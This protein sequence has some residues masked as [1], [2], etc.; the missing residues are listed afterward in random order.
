MTLFIVTVLFVDIADKEHWLVY[1]R[2]VLRDVFYFTSQKKRT[3]SSYIEP[4]DTEFESSCRKIRPHSSTVKALYPRDVLFFYQSTSG[5]YSTFYFLRALFPD[6]FSLVLMYLSWYSVNVFLLYCL[7]F[8]LLHL[9]YPTLQ[10]LSYSVT[11]ISRHEKSKIYVLLLS[12]IYIEH[13][14]DAFIFI[15]FAGHSNLNH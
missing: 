14:M 12:D 11:Y 7:D 4:A 13:Q 1:L 3:S 15:L 9:S 5:E 10:Q 8:P 2:N 6:W